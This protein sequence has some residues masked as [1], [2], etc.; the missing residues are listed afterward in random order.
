[1][2]IGELLAFYSFLGPDHGEKLQVPVIFREGDDEKWQ[3]IE[4]TVDRIEL[5]PHWMDP[6]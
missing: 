4:Y 3:F 5:T 2:I 1:M 6:L